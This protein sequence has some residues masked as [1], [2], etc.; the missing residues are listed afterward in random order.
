MINLTGYMECRL[1]YLFIYL[2]NQVIF[3]KVNTQFAFLSQEYFL[4]FES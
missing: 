1:F 3:T 2:E 4:V